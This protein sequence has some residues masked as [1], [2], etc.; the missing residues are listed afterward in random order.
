MTR[1]RPISMPTGIAIAQAIRKPSAMCCSAPPSA[2]GNSPLIVNSPSLF[3]TPRGGA[4]TKL[5]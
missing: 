4:S 5:E 2:R 1:T 3:S